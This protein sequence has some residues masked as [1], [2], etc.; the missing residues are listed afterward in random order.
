MSIENIILEFINTHYPKESKMIERSM[1]NFYHSRLTGEKTEQGLLH[2]QMIYD[3]VIDLFE[4]LSIKLEC[5]LD[6]SIT[7]GEIVEHLK[8]I[9][10]KT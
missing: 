4:L 2:Q 9:Y 1:I 3:G 5:K 7:S 10:I 8:N 6:L